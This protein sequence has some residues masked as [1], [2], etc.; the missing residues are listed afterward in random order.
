MKII[1]LSQS[2]SQKGKQ[3]KKMKILKLECYAA[4]LNF[5]LKI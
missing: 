1:I 4:S 3:L 2:A 5:K